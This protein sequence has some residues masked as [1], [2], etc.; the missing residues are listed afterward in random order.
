LGFELS[1][2]VEKKT[3][4]SPDGF[5]TGGERVLD[6]FIEVLQEPF[7]DEK[8]Y[9]RQVGAGLFVFQIPSLSY[10]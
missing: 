7:W 10:R 1:Y 9:F 4:A 3:H 8:P 2:F 6:C 5:A